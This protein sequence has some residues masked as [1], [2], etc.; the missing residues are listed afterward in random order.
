MDHVALR[1]RELMVETSLGGALR[2]C[3]ALGI[4]EC[5]IQILSCNL[6][7]MRVVTE[8]KARAGQARNI[9]RSV[10]QLSAIRRKRCDL[11]S[12]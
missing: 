1:H 5:R 12:G 9:D 10:G 6:W 11:A 3:L 4:H 7:T 2:H 8:R